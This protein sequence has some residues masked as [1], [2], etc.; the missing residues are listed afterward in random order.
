MTL[1]YPHITMRVIDT[2]TL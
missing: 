1:H 2:R